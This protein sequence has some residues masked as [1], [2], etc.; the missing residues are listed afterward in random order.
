M[1]L[2]T[3]YFWNSGGYHAAELGFLQP[4]WAGA[5]A[6]IEAGAGF[7]MTSVADT[8][9]AM[10]SVGVGLDQAFLT[11]TTV[12]VRY[13]YQTLFY[14]S[15]RVDPRHQFFLVASQRLAANW[16]VHAR[17]LRTIDL[18]STA[19]YQEGYFDMGVSYD[20]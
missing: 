2:G 4:L 17:Y 3:T 13:A 18:S 19:G 10:P 15:T 7:Y 11:G 14:S 5:S 20:F 6:R 8:S 9:F 16:E 1:L 12:G